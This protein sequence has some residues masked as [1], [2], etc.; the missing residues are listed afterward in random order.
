M[1]C[2]S[3]LMVQG[4]IIGNDPPSERRPLSTRPIAPSRPCGRCQLRSACFAALSHTAVG[5]S[6][7]CCPT[8][9]PSVSTNAP[10]TV[11]KVLQGALE[12]TPKRRRWCCFNDPMRAGLQTGVCKSLAQCKQTPTKPS[13]CHQSADKYE[14]CPDSRKRDVRMPPETSNVVQTLRAPPSTSPLPRPDQ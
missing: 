13:A 12:W 6:D 2:P 14:R 1:P 11:A 7:N 10:T 5:L 4:Q 3:A 8:A 9:P